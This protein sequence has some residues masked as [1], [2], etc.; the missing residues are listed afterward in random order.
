MAFVCPEKTCIPFRNGKRL[1]S[2]RI[3]AKMKKKKP[4]RKTSTRYSEDR[5]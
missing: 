3:F 5:K 2:K 4:I 1:L